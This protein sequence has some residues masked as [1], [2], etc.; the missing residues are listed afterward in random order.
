MSLNGRTDQEIV[1]HLHDGVL[2]GHLKNNTMKFRQM[3]GTK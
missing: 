1:L 3:D 2:L